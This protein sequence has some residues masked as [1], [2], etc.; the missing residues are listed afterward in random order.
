MNVRFE[1]D[2]LKTFIALFY[3]DFN[4]EPLQIFRLSNSANEMLKEKK[5][6]SLFSLD[7]KFNQET[8][9]LAELSRVV[10]LS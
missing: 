7:A 1:G 3:A 2:S 9:I 4:L 5:S 8:W 6:Q 10:R